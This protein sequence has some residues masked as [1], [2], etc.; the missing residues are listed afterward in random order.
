MA[1]IKHLLVAC[2][3]REYSKE[4]TK[5]EQQQEQAANESHSHVAA[6]AGAAAFGKSTFKRCGMK[7]KPTETIEIGRA[8]HVENQQELEQEQPKEET[9][10]VDFVKAVGG[11]P[12][13]RTAAA[14]TASPRYTKRTKMTTTAMATQTATATTATMPANVATRIAMESETEA[15]TASTALA[16]LN[17]APQLVASPSA[18]SETQAGIS[19][20]EIFHLPKNCVLQKILHLQLL[21]KVGKRCKRCKRK[22]HCTLWAV[23]Y[24]GFL[25][26]FIGAR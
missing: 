2:L 9:S 22:Q 25:F 12:Q 16:T 7:T 14:E 19:Q 23:G 18:P 24:H 21:V 10:I 5:E 20:A 8:E 1:L 3:L 26:I 17:P 13:R 6:A 11:Q 4:E 15:E